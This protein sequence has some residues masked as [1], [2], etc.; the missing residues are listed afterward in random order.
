MG[1]DPVREYNIIIETAAVSE[2]LPVQLAAVSVLRY[3]RPRFPGLS[4]PEEGFLLLRA[5]CFSGA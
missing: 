2:R 5:G 4:L 3:L 1:S